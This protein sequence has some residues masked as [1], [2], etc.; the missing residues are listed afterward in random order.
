MKRNISLNMGKLIPA[1]FACVAF[2]FIAACGESKDAKDAVNEGAKKVEEGAKAAGDKAPEGA[3]KDAAKKV[4]EGA[5][6]VKE[7]TDEK[8]E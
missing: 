1:L 2:A 6:K 3:A 5:A 7:A 4:E 8:P